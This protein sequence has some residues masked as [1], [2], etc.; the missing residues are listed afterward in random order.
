MHHIRR[1]IFACAAA[2]GLLGG[3]ATVNPTHDYQQAAAHIEKATGQAGAYH[4]GDEALTRQKVEDLLQN[5]L[6]AGEAVQVCLLNNPSLQA[7]FLNIGMARADVVQAGL[8]SNPS[9]FVSSRLP[10]GGGRSNIEA[11]FAQ[12]IADLW[13]I[14]V[15]KRAAKRELAQTILTISREAS[16]LAFDARAAYYATVGARQLHNITV[17]NL[18]IARE[19]MDMAKA[20][21]KAGAGNAID[22]NLALGQVA[23]A[24][25]LQESSRLAAAEAGR[26]LATLLGLITDPDLLVLSEPL[27]ESPT[28]APN[29]ER[30]IRL[31]R[32]WRLD[33]RAAEQA[34]GAAESRLEEQYRL[35]FPR[36]NVGLALERA[37]RRRQFGRKPLADTARASVAGGGLTAPEFQPRSERK[38]NRRTEFIIGPSLDLELPIFDQHQAQIA[39]ARYAYDQAI[40]TL[41]ALMTAASQEIRGA[42]DRLTTNWRIVKLYQEKFIPLARTNLDLSRKSYRAGRASF[43]SILEAQRFFLDSRRRYIEASQSAANTIPELERSVGRPFD[44]LIRETEQKARERDKAEKTEQGDGA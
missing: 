35:I 7:K 40:K 17:E 23:E 5:G 20:R 21:Q 39:K 15:R 2:L 19:L 33:L 31:A 16:D 9:L 44:D 29:S 22:V 42:V 8:F 30:L 12:N 13:Q 27:P 38:R 6:T 18:R 10:A 11:S 24:E 37:E 26:R 4:P 28:E 34:V 3:C 43:L 14:P 32:S 25:L 36:V 1:I 41:D